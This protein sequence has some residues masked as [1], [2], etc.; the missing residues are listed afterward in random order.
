VPYEGK[1]LIWH[2]PNLKPEVILK[3]K[4][5]DN[6]VLSTDNVRPRDTKATLSG[7]DQVWAYLNTFYK[8]L[9]E[10]W[11][12]VVVFILMIGFTVFKGRR[13]LYLKSSI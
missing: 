5:L 12:S 4:N 9:I 11:Q 3:E 13:Y 7:W 8:T 2:W 1:I 10:V 6:D